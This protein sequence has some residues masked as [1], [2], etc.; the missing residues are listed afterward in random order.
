MRQKRWVNLKEPAEII[1]ENHVA[2]E[3]KKAEFLV[4]SGDPE[5]NKMHAN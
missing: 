5:M 3:L 1:S 4:S 2:E